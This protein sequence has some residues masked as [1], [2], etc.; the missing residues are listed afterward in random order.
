[1]VI[2]LF[3]YLPLRRRVTIGRWLLIPRADLRDDDAVSAEVAQQARDVARLYRLPGDGGGFGA[4]VSTAEQRV[5]E[6][7]EEAALGRLYQTVVVAMLDENPSRADPEVEEHNA[8]HRICTTEN[9]QLFGH[10]VDADGYTAYSTG[11]MVTTLVGGPRVGESEDVIEPPNEMKLPLMRPQM[12]EVYAAALYDVLADLDEDGPDLPG[13]IRWLEVSWISARAVRVEARVLALRA[14]FDLLFGGAT[15]STIRERLSELLDE[16]NAP[17][18]R[19][20]WT[21][22]G[23]DREAD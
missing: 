17:R 7:F 21:G 18:T 8:G 6:E 23:N 13:A 2:W 20:Q 3:P 1:M 4:F 12:D 15:T 14:G 10:G 11:V 5:G 22:H 19:R 9:L 16:E